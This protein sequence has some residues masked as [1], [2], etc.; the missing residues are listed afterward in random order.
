MPLHPDAYRL[1]RTNLEGIG[2]GQKVHAV[3]VGV[4]TVA[5]VDAINA[6]RLRQGLNPIISEVLFVGGHIYRSRIL[7]DRYT[8]EDVIEQMFN[9]MEAAAIVLDAT[10]MTAM[11]NPN[12]RADRY[13][14]FVLD[15]VVFECST[16]HPRPELF[17]IIPRGDKIKP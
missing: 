17:S 2:E 11:E 10:H 16:R 9:A 8:I 14:N 13:G 12:P 4:L 3:H 15:R 7:R 6:A 1:L 5:Q